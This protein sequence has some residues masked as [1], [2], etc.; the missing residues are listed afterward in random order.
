MPQLEPWSYPSQIFWLVVTFVALYFVL[1][2]VVIPRITSVL[3]ARQE[4]IEDDLAR[5]ERLKTEA[6]QVLE[7]YNRSLD[8]ARSEA[9]SLVKDAQA[10]MAADA[11]ERSQALANELAERN[12]EAEARIAESQQAALANSRPAAAE[13]AAAALGKL[14]GSAPP[15]ERIERAVEAAAGDRT[16]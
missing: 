3:E 5:A 9:Q 7:E 1:S 15:A 14:I 16:A 13:V 12:R 6:G 11:A 4:K 10:A 8:E 2:K